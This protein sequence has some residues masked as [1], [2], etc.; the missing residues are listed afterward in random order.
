VSAEGIVFDLGAVVHE[1][2]VLEAVVLEAVVFDPWR[3]CSRHA[4]DVAFSEP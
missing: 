4:L 1:A 3:N 2:V